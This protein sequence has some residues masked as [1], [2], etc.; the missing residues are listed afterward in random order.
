MSTAHA[1]YPKDDLDNTKVFAPL[2]DYRAGGALFGPDGQPLQEE[3]AVTLQPGD[4]VEV[5]EDG[6]LTPKIQS[7]QKVELHDQGW[8][9]AE[10]NR[11]EQ[12]ELAKIHLAAISRAVVERHEVG[13]CRDGRWIN[14]P[15]EFPDLGLTGTVTS[16]AVIPFPPNDKQYFIGGKYN[17]KLSHLRHTAVP[18]FGHN[19]YDSSSWIRLVDFAQHAD[20]VHL[21]DEFSAKNHCG[22]VLQGAL[23]NGYFV[24]ALQA[25]AMRPKL[26]KQMFYGW[27][28][29]R[30][31][32]IARLFKHGTWM[33]VE[34]DD[35]V[36]VGRPGR[37]TEENVPVCCRSEHFP[38]VIWPCII[39]KAFAKIHTL[40]GSTGSI[41][42]EDRG[43]WE[44]LNGGGKTEEALADLTG[45]VAGR[46]YTHDVSPDRLFIYIYELQRDTLFVCRPNEEICDLYGVRLNPYYPNVV[47]RAVQWEGGLY[48]QIFCGAPGVFDGGLQD[49]TVPYSL[50]H[51]EDYPETTADG[52]FWVNH[53]DFSQ[54]FKE[55]FECR[56]VNSGDVAIPNMPQPRFETIR[57]PPTGVGMPAGMFSAQAT[58]G[59]MQQGLGPGSQQALGMPG[60]NTFEN[61]GT[62]FLQR[63]VQHLAPDGTPLP[64]YEW[65]YAN[66]GDIMRTNE[67]EFTISVPEHDCPCEV[68]CSVEQ[69]DLRL[70]LKE[71]TRPEAAP[72]LCKVYERV[73]GENYFSSQMVCRSNWIPVRD[74][75]VA[76]SVNRGGEFKITAE[77]PDGKTHVNKMVFRCYAT[78]PHVMVSASAMSRKHMLVDTKELPGASRLSL[79]GLMEPDGKDKDAPIH[80]DWEHDGLRK[81]EFDIEPGLTSMVK[82]IQED[83]SV[84]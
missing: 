60:L 51:C 58:A 73:A 42:E 15:N 44:A 22:R 67:P 63:G 31:V 52:F 70:Q 84:M 16:N 68:V 10:S 13:L 30:S 36:P 47:N 12:E 27:N 61:L 74:S 1:G 37:D 79:V 26:V 55:I 57:P 43:G 40:R 19:G 23:D 65:I 33:R 11:Y 69:V 14:D 38:N 41:T 18:N 17:P 28:S 24:E 25:I 8:F 50:M 35:Y 48:I 76:F 4:T 54:Y 29:R 32:Y 20:A 62:G 9:H 66:P 56:L 83:C 71:P 78:R 64:W 5:Q 46:F 75:M 7:H 82:E 6:S 39:E 53:N 80:L 59:F 2:A 72:I 49:I 77:L 21:F 81:P 45:G 3:A 34:V